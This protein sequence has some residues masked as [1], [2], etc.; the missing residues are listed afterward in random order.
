MI[1]LITTFVLREPNT[2]SAPRKR[3]LAFWALLCLLAVGD[4]HHLA[5]APNV[6][7]RQTHTLSS[8]A[9]AHGHRHAR[10]CIQELACNGQAHAHGPRNEQA[11]T[12]TH[13]SFRAILRDKVSPSDLDGLVHER[14]E[15]WCRL[16]A[17]ALPITHGVDL[18]C[19][20]KASTRA[21]RRRSQLVGRQLNALLTELRRLRVR[22]RKV[23]RTLV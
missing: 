20:L 19:G 22:E 23:R 4:L 1:T 8:Q 18:T 3:T 5:R 17:H 7:L 11:H 14:P 15:A 21:L 9:R 16:G 13:R 6:H 12:G 10:A 2:H